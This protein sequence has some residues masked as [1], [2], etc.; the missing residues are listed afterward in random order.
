MYH[1]VRCYFDEDLLQTTQ[2]AAVL[3]T[4]VWVCVR[5]V[6]SHVS[7]QRSAAEWSSDHAHQPHVQPNL[8]NKVVFSSILVDTSPHKKRYHS[9]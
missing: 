1:L 4:T 8:E 2:R 6:W 5:V 9:P 7:V 3:I